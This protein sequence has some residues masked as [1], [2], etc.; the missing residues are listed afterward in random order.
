MNGTLRLGE[1]PEYTEDLLGQ[2]QEH[3]ITKVEVDPED[4]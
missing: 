2:E 3:E 4:E 1:D